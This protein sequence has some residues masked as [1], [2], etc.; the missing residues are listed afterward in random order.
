M[1][2]TSPT[3]TGARGRK[4]GAIGLALAALV[5]LFWLDLT[6]QGAVWRFIWART[7]EEDPIAQIRGIVEWAGNAIRQ[8]LNLA[9]HVPINHKTDVPYGI[10]TFLQKE[11]EEPKMRVQL[12]MIKDVGFVWLRQEFPWEDL[13]VDGRGQFTDSRNDYNGDGIPDTIDAWA[14]YDRIVNLTEEYG[15]RL[16]VRLSNPPNWSRAHT[17]DTLAGS[18][19]PP[20]DFQD[21]VN[22][23]VAVAQRYKGRI[24]HYQVWNEPNIYPEWGENFADP[25]AYT[26]LLC[27]TYAAL[28]QVDPHIVVLSGALAPTISLDGFYGYSDLIYLQNMYD[29]GA[30][31]CFDVMSVQGYGLFSGPTDQR[32]RVT[33][34]N[35]ARNLYIRDVMV[36]NGDAHKPIWISE[37]AWNPVLDAELPPQQIVQYSNYGEVTEAQAAR[38]MPLAYQR[39]QEDWP[40]VGVVNYWFFTRPDDSEKGQAFYYFR[41]VEPDY[42][43]ERPTF[44]PLPVYHA[45]KDYIANQTPTLYSGTHQAETWQVTAV[46]GAQSVAA[47]DAQFGAALATT[48]ARFMAYGT[49]VW[50]RWRPDAASP[51]RM[52]PLADSWQAQTHAII[53]RP[54]GASPQID[55]FIVLDDSARR[56]MPLLGLGLALGG[57]TGYVLFLA[58]RR[59]TTP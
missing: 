8:P 3:A 45:M 4:K 56:Q 27:Q 22:Y 25:A 23:A 46:E 41:M 5:A 13:E 9:P 40:W 57:F 14:K 53:F 31:A 28:K 35:F 34:V 6:Q 33:T 18:L 20:D 15:L 32:L 24:H 50:A 10:N 17:P 7:G 12:Q 1:T 55:A 43:P 26:R 44:T 58:W 51:W 52:L 59:R 47:D 54:Q 2:N 21:F 48:E 42:Q 11:V 49:A 29:H 39:A 19:G 38:Y 36:Q 30:G 16:I 37:A